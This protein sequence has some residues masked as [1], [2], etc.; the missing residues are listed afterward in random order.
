MLSSLAIVD[1]T[2]ANFHRRVAARLGRTEHDTRGVKMGEEGGTR[3]Q[4]CVVGGGPAGM[5][6]GYL[7]ARA[8]VETIVL[9]KQ[10]TI[11]NRVVRGI[12]EN[13]EQPAVLSALRLLDKILP[14]QRLP[15]RLIGPRRAT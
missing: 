12:L 1:A 15:A 5:M 6:L 8:G 9:E 11:Q 2:L 13:R 4:C 7:L 14:L 10:V 3:T